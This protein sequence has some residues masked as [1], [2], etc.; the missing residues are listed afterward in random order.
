MRAL[1]SS[2]WREQT[3]SALHQEGIGEKDLEGK[4]INK[5]NQVIRSIES[6]ISV[7][8]RRI[9]K[10]QFM[11]AFGFIGNPVTLRAIF[12]GLIGDQ[13]EP[14]NLN[15]SEIDKPE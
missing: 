8:E 6:E 10:K 9:N 11:H 1:R 15:Q 7:Y 2:Y 14:A 12:K 5:C 13:S 3:H 4:L